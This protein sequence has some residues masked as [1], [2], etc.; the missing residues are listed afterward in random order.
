LKITSLARAR[1]CCLSFSLFLVCSL[2]QPPSLGLYSINGA[3]GA[4]HCCT[5]TESLLVIDSTAV[6]LRSHALEIVY[7]NTLFSGYF[8]AN[9]R[10]HLDQVDLMNRTRFSNNHFVVA[11]VICVRSPAN[12]VSNALL[13]SRATISLKQNRW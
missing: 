5:I 13:A 6:A 9:A 7:N 10:S 12:E 2:S 8:A 1:G 11:L 3:T 4:T